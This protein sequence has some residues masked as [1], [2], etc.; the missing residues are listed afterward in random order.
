MQTKQS[1]IQVYILLLAVICAAIAAYY[2]TRKNSG[3]P[4]VYSHTEFIQRYEQKRA[5]SQSR[6]L[7]KEATSPPP[8]E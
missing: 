3:E 6:N 5:E 8:G 2:I 1:R 7:V 4:G